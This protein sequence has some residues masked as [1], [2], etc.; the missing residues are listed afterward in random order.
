VGCD[1]GAQ[2]NDLGHYTS[3]WS[4]LVD[5]KLS[6]RNKAEFIDWVHSFGSTVANS[7]VYRVGH[8]QNAISKRCN[9]TAIHDIPLPSKSPR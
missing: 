8:A 6:S 5:V 4:W 3:D 2:S 7:I 1:L 9:Q